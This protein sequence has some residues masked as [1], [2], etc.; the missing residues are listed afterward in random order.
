MP[1]RIVVGL[2]LLLALPLSGCGEGLFSASLLDPLGIARALLPNEKPVRIGLACEWGGLFDVRRWGKQAPWT[3]LAR[4]LSEELGRPVVIENLRPFQIRF[5]LTDSDRLQFALLGATDYAAI[6]EDG[7]V[8]TVL[9]VSEV[10]W[11]Q[12]V[13]VCNARSEIQSLGDLAGKRF[14]FGPEKDA[15]LH[16]ATAA[17]LEAAGVPPDKLAT[18]AWTTPALTP[19]P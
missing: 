8:G 9:A 19:R 2:V 1:R 15:V 4:A 10:R 6:R 5:H 14:A 11:R 13:I 3:P 12:G 16:T 7:A 18:S 17:L